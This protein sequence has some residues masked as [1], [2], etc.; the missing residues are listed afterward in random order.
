MKNHYK[1]VLVLLVFLF[2]GL[3]VTGIGVSFAYY[4]V[5]VTGTAS[6]RSSDYD[7][8]IEVVSSTH[9][10]LPASNAVVDTVEFYI[11]NYTGTDNSPTNTS[12][13]YLSYILTFTLPTWGSGC[14]N[15][16]SYQLYSIAPTTNAE[17][18]VSLNSSNQTPEIS[19]SLATQEKQHYKLKLYWDMANNGAS[20]FAG[21]SGNVGISASMYQNPSVYTVD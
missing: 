7:G 6:T 11:K 5:G 20:C 16:I 2:V 21:K 13:V 12:E 1:G 17:T 14:T 19:F 10:I 8:E 18:L 9:S 15:P 3:M 4:R